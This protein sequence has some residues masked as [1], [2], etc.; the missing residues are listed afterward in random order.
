MKPKQKTLVV[1]DQAL[2]RIATAV[3][4]EDLGFEVH[5][6]A[7]GR[8]ALLQ[9]RA[10]KYDVIVM[11]Y[12]MPEMNGLDCSQRIREIEGTSGSDVDRVTII[13]FSGSLEEDIRERCLQAG[14]DAFVAKSG[15]SQQLID[16]VNRFTG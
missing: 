11:D 6:A 16:V 3:V 13:A 8:E 2:N 4:L 5:L 15:N 10:N 9:F 1:D 7:S 14:I 12:E